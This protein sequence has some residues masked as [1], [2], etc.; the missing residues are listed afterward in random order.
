MANA[1]DLN[2]RVA[3]WRMAG[4]GVLLVVAGVAGAAY[5]W[6]P[7]PPHSTTAPVTGWPA[8]LFAAGVGSFGVVVAVVGVAALRGGAGRSLTRSARAAF[9]L[10]LVSWSAW[11]V[12]LLQR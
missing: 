8:R 3:A 2:D 11:L 9:A 4:I 7:A 5:A 1:T 6:F 12:S 10:A